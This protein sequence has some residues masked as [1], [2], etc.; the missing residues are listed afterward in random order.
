MPYPTSNLKQA[1]RAYFVGIDDQDLDAVD[2]LVHQDIVMIFANAEPS[3]GK[4]IF[5]ANAKVRNP[6][7]AQI[8][9]DLIEV[10]QPD[11]DANVVIATMTVTYER[12]DGIVVAVP[13]CGIFEFDGGQ[14]RRYRVFIDRAPAVATT[15][16][17][18]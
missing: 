5:M 9:H 2:A 11:D 18:A 8:R 7:F 16:A 15:P 4:Q 12:L 14:I 6:A 1:V 17:Q 13:C 10:W 3:V